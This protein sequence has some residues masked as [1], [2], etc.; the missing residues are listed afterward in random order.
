MNQCEKSLPDKTVGD[1]I[2]HYAYLNDQA[3]TALSYILCKTVTQ[4]KRR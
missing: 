3:L 1:Y 2:M 4:K